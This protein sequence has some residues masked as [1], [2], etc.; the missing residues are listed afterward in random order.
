MAYNNGDTDQVEIHESDS[1]FLGLP[2]KFLSD[3]DR[4]II[5]NLPLVK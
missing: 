2:Y 3:N 4:Q 5:V 1:W